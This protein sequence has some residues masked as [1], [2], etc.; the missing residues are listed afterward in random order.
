MGTNAYFGLIRTNIPHAAPEYG[1]GK[2]KFEVDNYRQTY[3]YSEK[4]AHI[5]RKSRKS[6]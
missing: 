2:Y 4:L 6:G 1:P 3:F 5:R